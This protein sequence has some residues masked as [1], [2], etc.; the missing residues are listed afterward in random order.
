MTRIR[1]RIQ[2]GASLWLLTACASACGDPTAPGG[3]PEIIESL[4]R[5]LTVTEREIID[6]SNTFAFDL[7]REVHA[8]EGAS[9]NVFLSPLSASMALAMTMNGAAGETFDEMRAT[10]G[11]AGLGQDEINRSYRDLTAMLL[12]LDARVELEIANSTWA[13]QGF[14]F[15][16]AFFDAVTEWF[17]AEARELDFADP[18]AVDAINGWAADRTN[19]R[20]EK[21]ID[22]IDPLHIL[23]LLNAVYFKG[24]WTDRFDPDDTRTAPF[25]LADGSEIQVQRMNGK[26]E[27]G[28]A[29]VDGV[30]IGELP[31]GGRAF[32]MTIV[33]PPRDGS[34]AALVAGLD[35]ATW[36]R[37]IDAVGEYH[38]LTVGLPKVELEYETELNDA[39]VAMGM[40][41]AFD[42]RLAD[43]SRLTPEPAWIDFVK[44]N[45]FLR[46]D[47]EGTEAA[48]VTTVG[49]G[50]TS[51][52]PML[53][54]DRPYLLAIRERLSGTILFLGAIGDPRG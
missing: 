44:Q 25:T 31:Y 37:W 39:L 3:A 8:R 43:F 38:E 13:R 53:I 18:A 5:A 29:R 51:A 1:V 30:E 2:Q 46:V 26:P 33:L 15:E 48:A 7:L 40:V 27:A 42:D 6:A 50:T 9:P 41:R 23:F 19:G 22:R 47:E 21:V 24:Q 10:L 45:T 28:L 49:I 52:G 32:V 54:V 12:E 14:P 34:L 36:E 20:I 4:P 16:P 11:F 17:D 35:A